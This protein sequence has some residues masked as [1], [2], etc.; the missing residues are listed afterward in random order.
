MIFGRITQQPGPYQFSVRK[1]SS[2]LRISEPVTNVR[3]ELTD[4]DRGISETAVVT[5][6]G[7]Y[8][9]PGELVQGRPGG[10]YQLQVELRGEGKTFL[11][12]PQTM[13]EFVAT[14][15]AYFSFKRRTLF[16]DGGADFKKWFID[17]LVDS[18]FPQTEAPFYL[19]WDVDEVF[20]FI[21]VIPGPFPTYIDCYIQTWPEQRGFVLLN[22]EDFEGGQ[23]TG[24]LLASKLIDHTFE[25]RHYF[26]INQ[27]SLNR[28]AFEYWQ[29]VS[30]MVNQT[31]SIFDIPPAPIRGN[32][33][34]PD[35]PDELVLGFFEACQLNTSRFFIVKSMLPL[36]PA[37]PCI[38]QPA[39]CDNC[40]SVENNLPERPEWF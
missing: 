36:F 30:Q 18:G 9:V 17:V 11:S 27:Y 19:R 29:Q 20:S 38:V 6:P 4:L 21:N 3:V 15:S 7:E 33:H 16:T 5:A 37:D 13:P 23:L 10:T 8:E 28:E 1:T 34:N 31:G 25:E 39:I 14:D 2:N 35:N 40:K 22:G 32:L 24:Q 26:N 12:E